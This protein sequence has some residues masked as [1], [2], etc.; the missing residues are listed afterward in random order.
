MRCPW[1]L[2]PNDDEWSDDLCRLHEAE[3][4][5]ISLAELDRRDDEQYAEYCDIYGR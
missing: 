4:E 2:D 5:G 3:Y 1:C